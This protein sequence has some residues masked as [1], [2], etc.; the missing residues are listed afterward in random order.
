MV[1]AVLVICTVVYMQKN[2]RNVG[3]GAVHP[4]CVSLTNLATRAC[5]CSY[6]TTFTSV[7]II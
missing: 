2:Q 6:Y 1:I 4:E 5:L 7:R 3:E